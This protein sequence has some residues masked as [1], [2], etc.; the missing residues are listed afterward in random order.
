[1]GVRKS[2]CWLA[3]PAI[4]PGRATCHVTFRRVNMGNVLYCVTVGLD[5]FGAVVIQLVGRAEIVS[6]ETCVTVCI[7]VRGIERGKI[8]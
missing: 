5:L 7:A 2:C 3:S 4:L 8:I 1:V 6:G